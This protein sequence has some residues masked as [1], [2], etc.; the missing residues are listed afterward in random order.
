MAAV[1]LVDTNLLIDV[2]FLR[3]GDTDPTRKKFTYQTQYVRSQ[4][5][6]E[7]L[8]RTL[9]GGRAYVLDVVSFESGW[10]IRRDIA[11]GGPSDTAVSLFHRIVSEL[12]L[13]PLSSADLEPDREMRRA[14][15]SCDALQVA[16]LRDLQ[17]RGD[18]PTL[19]TGEENLSRW[20]EARGYSVE[21]FRSEDVR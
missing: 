12:R 21:R 18:R 5:D 6:L 14:Y 11:F 2:W 9:R 3:Y 8:R 17:R 16:C 1:L 7:R 20:C 19:V 10:T 13:S 15:G 4:P